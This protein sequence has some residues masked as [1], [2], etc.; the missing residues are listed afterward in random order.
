MNASGQGSVTI[1]ND[2]VLKLVQPKTGFSLDYWMTPTFVVFS[3]SG[4]SKRVVLKHIAAVQVAFADCGIAMPSIRLMESLSPIA[5][6]LK[7]PSRDSVL[8]G[9]GLVNTILDGIP[10]NPMNSTVYFVG[11]FSDYLNG[12]AVPFG[13]SEGGPSAQPPSAGTAWIN[14]RMKHQEA[15]EKRISVVAHEIGHT[16]G[17]PEADDSELMYGVTITESR[18]WG[19]V[20]SSD[21][22]NCDRNGDLKCSFTEKECEAMKSSPLVHSYSLELPYTSLVN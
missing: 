19:T 7:I 14:A 2:A 8:S 10:P 11:N 21:T 20:A 15:S 17:L 3:K 13:D 16:L 22:A 9:T 1:S 18:P 12:Q 4:W 5:G 6:K